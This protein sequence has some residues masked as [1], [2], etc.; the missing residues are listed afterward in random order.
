[1]NPYAQELARELGLRPEQVDRTLALHEK[2]ATIPFM[3]RY[4]KEATGG[5]DEV[6]IQ[7]VLEGAERRKELDDRRAA[8][9]KSIEEQG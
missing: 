7:A 2:G 9:R 8:V 4:R 3:A 5:M 1:M 6:Q